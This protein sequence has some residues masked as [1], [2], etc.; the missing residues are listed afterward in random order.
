MFLP[1]HTHCNPLLIFQRLITWQNILLQWVIAK[2]CPGR[3]AKSWY[4]WI[5][6]CFVL[7]LYG[8][9]LTFTF[10]HVRRF[11]PKR[12]TY[13]ILWAILTGAIWGEVSCP[14]TQRHADCRGVWTCAPPDPNTNALTHYATLPLRLYF[15]TK[16]TG[17]TVRRALGMYDLLLY[18]DPTV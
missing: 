2:R 9:V 3:I 5:T 16:E 6:L 18:I 15:S 14:G 10:V 7:P 13:S 11:Y 4:I 8:S 17:Q 1:K 12:L